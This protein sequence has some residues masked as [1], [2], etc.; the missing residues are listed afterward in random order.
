LPSF[1][2]G[3]FYVQDPSTLLAVR[4]LDPHPGETILD[5][6]AAP[7]GKLTW[8]AQL[9]KNE[10]ALVAYDI[11]S[12]RIQLINQNCAR[13][14]I[15]CVQTICSGQF[16]TADL[17]A[18]I[19]TQSSTPGLPHRFDRVLVDA[20]CSNS[21]VM[22]RRVDLRWR[23]RPEEI[24]RLRRTQ[25]KLLQTAS[26]LLRPAGHLVYSTCSLE[27]EEN[28]SV[29]TDFLSSHPGY[30]LEAQRTLLPQSDHVDGAYIA[31][32]RS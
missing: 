15:T 11:A 17:L 7:G 23:I 26:E 32:L 28:E 31:R 8:T 4:E 9:M 29:V 3:F 24:D 27:P 13:L 12:D 14:G 6:C 19:N 30:K 5:L 21:G 10:G 18:A 22:R 25:L 16:P 20:P 1:Q 2:Q